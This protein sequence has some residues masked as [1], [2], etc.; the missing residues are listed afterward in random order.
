MP[1][2]EARERK[3]EEEYNVYLL[4]S[5]HGTDMMPRALHTISFNPLNSPM[6]LV[7]L[8]FPFYR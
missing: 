4:E 2:E 7:L 8:S 1:L 3:L 5:E 6:W